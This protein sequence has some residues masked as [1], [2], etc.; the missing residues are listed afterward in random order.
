[1]QDPSRQTDTTS[2]RSFYG[3]NLGYAA[4]M[5]ELYKTNPDAVDASWREFFATHGA[6]L[7]TSEEH[8]GESQSAA[9][10]AY[11][12]QKVVALHELLRNVV[13]YGHLLAETNP[14]QPEKVDTPVLD[15]AYHGLSEEDMR[16]IPAQMVLPDAPASVETGWDAF[17]WLKSLYTGNISF[18]FAQ[19]HRPRE[20]E[21]LRKFV[22]QNEAS[23]HLGSDEK[24]QLLERLTEV[25]EFETFLHRTFVGQK[26]F[27]IEGV[28]ALVPMM[29]EI[30]RN[31]IAKGAKNVMIGMAHRGRLNVLAHV[32]QKPY[33][34]IFSEFHTAVNKEL[35]P[36]EG[37]TG[38]NFGWSGDVKYH[39]GG[40][41]TMNGEGAQSVRLVLA[42]NPSHLEFV[43]PVV[44]GFA[45][46]AQDD[47]Q[48]PGTPQQDV[49]STLAILVH[50]DAAFPGEGVVAETLNLSRLA[51][52][53]TGGTIHIITNNLLGFTATSQEGRSTRYASDLAK[54][55]EIPIVHVNA[56]DPEACL[57]AVRLAHAY[58]AEFHKD[59]LIDL[60][61]YRRWGHNEG[62]DPSVTSPLLYEKVNAHPR[63][64][65][66]Y[67]K[68]LE[69]NQVI[70]QG[71]A[72]EYV[73]RIQQTLKNAY[74]DVAKVTEDEADNGMAAE[75]LPP[76][77]TGV[78]KDELMQINQ[79]LLQ[80]PESFTPYP[81]LHR[82]LQRRLQAFEKDGAVDW[83]HAETL[84]FAT[85]L[86]EGTPI[87]LTG[88]D[89]ERGTFSQRHLVLHDM[90]GGPSYC[91]LHDLSGAKAS[92]DIHNS[93]LSEMGVLGFEYGYNVLA[94]KTM[95]L[96]E[97]QYGDFAN[98]AQGIIDQFISAGYSKWKQPSG[99]VLLLP[100][101]YE[102]QG[103]EH[104]SARLERYLSLSAENNWRVV[105]P[106]TAA[107]YFHLLR[108]QARRLQSEPRPLIVMAPK[109]LLRNPH[110]A[111][112]WEE[113]TKGGFQPLLLTAGQE[114]PDADVR[115]LV[116]C[117]GKV[118]VE[119]ETA[120]SETKQKVEDLRVLRLE[121]LYPFPEKEIQAQLQQL[122]N[123][124]EVVFLQEEPMN[125]GA[126]SYV[127]P[128]LLN[129]L[130][131]EVE[132]R[133]CG[134]PER[135]SP[136]EGK[137]GMHTAMQ[138]AILEQAMVP[139]TGRVLA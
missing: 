40:T 70:R 4:E 46:A 75:L 7:P 56:D 114:L 1:M 37:S 3:P 69:A 66:I 137:A 60:I 20:R 88:Q 19:V 115:R 65:E 74:A 8:V 127:Q 71:E 119:F 103:P 53:S 139:S 106:T 94:P 108:D 97:A 138:K 128:R 116:V 133:Y 87:R 33:A 136:A 72:D 21:W 112:A 92:F 35:V 31:A 54:G 16:S 109:S 25:E 83:G 100:H 57:F 9:G 6:P 135:C 98:T 80:F 32:L 51:G 134:R 34:K 130:S 43:D 95:V 117:T 107:Q 49:D 45:R 14:L 77:Q 85:I 78:S 42:N 102:G 48:R 50:G 28:D 81:K 73:A 67:A 44:E 23:C 5:Y 39:L 30:I 89:S 86:R 38:I 2:W 105:Y 59:F 79:E 36:S 55:Y 18:E 47:R 63:V 62:D 101:G 52:Y 68:R 26:R 61:G 111:S 12:I 29:D 27:S 123:L 118:A 113:F 124:K 129:L 76:A 13:E 24:K 99:L 132:L 90:N 22:E 120:L 93:P 121:Q 11:A 91:P 104:S 110:A 131:K 82:I 15:P 122:Q 41:R 96:W 126:W 17:L 10:S 125:M 84:A 64:R 58:R